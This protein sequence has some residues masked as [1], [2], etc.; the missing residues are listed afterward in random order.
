M[1][2]FKMYCVNDKTQESL[3]TCKKEN[4]NK[5]KMF[6]ASLKGLTMKDFL[7]IYNVCEFNL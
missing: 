4:I 1:T 3:F 5:A 7:K 2:K 6:F